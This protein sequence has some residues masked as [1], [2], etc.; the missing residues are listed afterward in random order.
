VSDVTLNGLRVLRMTLVMPL[1]GAWTAEVE[2]D[3]PTAPVGP[4]TLEGLGATLKGFV[5]KGEAFAELVRVS[6][7]GGAG[8]LGA[9]IPPKFYE[10]TTMRTVL[11]DIAR[12]AGEAISTTSDATILATTV[13]KWVRPKATARAAL[14]LLLRQ[15]EGATWRVL[16]DGTVWVGRDAWG[17]SAADYTV[18]DYDPAKS[19]LK[20]WGDDMSLRPGVTWQG[21][22]LHEVVHA[23]TPDSF[24]T[25]AN[26]AASLDDAFKGAVR[27]LVA[28]ELTA[29]RRYPATVVAQSSDGA[30]LEVRP[31]SGAIPGLTR[32][33]FR[34]GLPGFRAKVPRGARVDVAFENGDLS[35]PFALPGELGAVTEVSFDGGSKGVARVDDTTFSGEFYMQAAPGPVY[36]LWYKPPGGAWGVVASGA[37]PPVAAGTSVPG[38]ITSGQAKLKA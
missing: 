38:K 25:R 12:E 7:A 26:H 10:G 31:D 35:R 28:D 14:G 33:P 30:L 17:A 23:L 37:I 29:A 1:V 19:F 6:L 36:T 4:V 22:R 16:D 34:Y 9:V 8:G 21:F 32:L 11:D 2:A 18:E 27:R 15:S 5:R 3:A 24:R 13:G 20:L